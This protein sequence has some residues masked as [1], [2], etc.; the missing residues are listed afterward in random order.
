MQLQLGVE[1]QNGYLVTIKGQ[2]CVPNDRRL[3]YQMVLEHHDQVFSGHWSVEKTLAQ[4]RRNYFWP[5]MVG[6]V[7]EVVDTCGVCQRSRFQKKTDRAPIR[8]I[9]AQYPW[10]VVTV[11]FVSGFAPT[12]RKHTAICVICDRFTRMMHAEPCNDHATAKETAK[13]MVRRLFSQHGCPRVLISDRGAEFDSELWK[14]FWNMMGTRVHLATTHHSQ[15]NGLTERM[16]RTLIGLVRKVTQTRKHNWDELLPMLEFAYNQTPN[17]TTGI[18]PFEAQQGYLPVVPSTL[19]V[20]AQMRR[21]KTREVEE[22]VQEIRRSYSDIQKAIL[23]AEEKAKQTIG[24]RENMRR[25]AP[26]FF[27]G[28][29]VLVYWEPFMTYS[30]QPRKH[31][32]RYQEPFT[33]KEV[34]H[35][36]CVRLEGLP[37]KMPDMINVEYVHLFRRSCEPELVELRDEQSG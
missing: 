5:T 18:A 27:V 33:V 31:R 23:E 17:A 7:Q 15:S 26:E 28:D 13:I 6:D 19:L 25:K 22:F 8:F 1:E 2:L 34:K 37:D 29:E 36:H 14:Y 12:K 32:F 10:E 16:N 4:L 21:G 11:D 24:E 9:E 30:P 35:P 20:A 3:R